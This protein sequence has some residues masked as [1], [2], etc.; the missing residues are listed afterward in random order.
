MCSPCLVVGVPVSKSLATEMP[1]ALTGPGIEE[2]S[3]GV[4]EAPVASS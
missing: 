1:A 2:V 3:S 4:A